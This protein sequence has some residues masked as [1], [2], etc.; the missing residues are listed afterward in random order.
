MGYLGSRATAVAAALVA[1]MAVYCGAVVAARGTT[2]PP[3]YSL[4]N[5][6]AFGGEPSIAVNRKG[7]LYDTTPSGGTVLYK[8]TDHGATWTKT[9]TADTSSGDDC[10]FTDH[11]G[12]LYL[13][14][15]AGSQSTGPLQA[16]IWKSFNDGKSWVYG[17]NPINTGGK[18]ICGTSCNP[19]GVDRP[20]AAAYIPP[21]HTT[22]TAEVVLM[23]H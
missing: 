18:N 13:C 10:V 5:V 17:N 4:A 9:T 1:F 11:A 12:K 3:G 7:E 6:G 23:Y 16:D 15:L 21:G 20:W 19:F 8:S 22:K 14:N 2:T